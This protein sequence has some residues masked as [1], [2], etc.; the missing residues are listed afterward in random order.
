M[1]GTGTEAFQYLLDLAFI[2]GLLVIPAFFL[3]RHV[4]RV[5]RRAEQVVGPEPPPASFS[6]N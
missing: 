3:W 6:S 1:I 2:V 4:V 5:F